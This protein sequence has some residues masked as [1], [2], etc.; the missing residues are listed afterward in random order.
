M[1]RLFW[2][3]FLWFWLTLLLISATVFVGTAFYLQGEN[4]DERRRW[5]PAVR[6]QAVSQVLRFSGEDAVKEMLQR[7]KNRHGQ[8]PVIVLNEQGNDILG[9]PVDQRLI[10]HAKQRLVVAPDGKEYRILS[11]PRDGPRFRERR[12]PPIERIIGHF[13]KRVV[14]LWLGIALALSGIV[15]FWLAW[16]LTRPI[17]QLQRAAQRLSQGQ[18]DT[19]V[20][21][22]IGN[23]RDEIADLGKDFDVMAEHLQKLINNQK[24]LLSD[25]SHELRSPLARLQVALG[26]ARKKTGVEAEADLLRIEHETGR[27]DDLI[28]QSLTLSR[29][30]AG[31]SYLMDDYIDVA[32]LLE[33]IINDGNFEA[34]DKNKKVAFSYTQSWTINV[35]AELLRRALEN[36]IRNAIN[37]TQDNSTVEVALKENPK[38]TQEFIIS[39]CDQG[40]GVPE[41]KLADLFEP[42]VR[43]SSARDRDSGGY[44]LGLTIAKRA[45][46]FH[47]GSITAKNRTSQGLCIDIIL[48]ANTA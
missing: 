20:S 36:V 43:L 41:D 34:R 38:N 10:D 4:D 24:Q 19:R 13:F 1:G 2:K 8:P 42:F 35:N 37:Y 25:V 40:S 26:L 22:Q 45:V 31:A 28:G 15:C 12:P 23:R 7:R 27:L 3:I 33:E 30:D 16:Y 47:Q 11:S 32:T 29:L 14:F 5:R 6:T 44:G 21:H 39:I 18:L 17:H 48:P 9:R 46:L